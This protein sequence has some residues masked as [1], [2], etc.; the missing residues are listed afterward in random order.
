MDNLKTLVE[1][2][3]FNNGK[4]ELKTDVV[5]RE[6]SFTIYINKK[7]FIALTC[8]LENLPELAIGFL[9][10]EGIVSDKKE[11]I[12]YDFRR[13]DMSIDF[14]LKIPEQRIKS[15]FEAGEKTSGCGSTLSS[16]IS[17]KK[18][19][20]PEIKIDPEN[21][22]QLMKEMNIN[23]K[24]FRETGGVHTACL[25]QNEKIISYA[26]DIGRHN[27]VD[28]IFGM[29]I[30][31]NIDLMKCLLLTSGRISSE[32]VKKCIRIGIPVVISRS[33]PTSEAIRLGWDYKTYIIGFA[34]GKRFNLY[35]GVEEINLTHPDP[36]FEKREGD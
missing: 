13:E 4:I 28:K 23:S 1:I 2:K 24:L 18:N 16:A 6:K 9:F 3:S 29:A 30:I 17:G 5:V 8:I 10:S 12:A 22:L 14:K 19:E 27:A 25:I 26:D 21:I 34:R 33:A 7:R 36:L 32:I 31:Q 20:F 11:I 35:T 15:F